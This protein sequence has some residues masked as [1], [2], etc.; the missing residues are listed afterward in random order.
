MDGK[1]NRENMNISG[2]FRMKKYIV[3]YTRYWLD[4]EY[5]DTDMS[6]EIIEAE[7]KEEARRK[8]K[9]KFVNS[10]TLKFHIDSVNIWEE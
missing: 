4:P 7:T 9:E 10:E 3:C 1:K 8:F 2:V 5:I 6:D